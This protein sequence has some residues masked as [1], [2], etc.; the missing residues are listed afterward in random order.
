MIAEAPIFLKLK[1]PVNGFW[2]SSYYGTKVFWRCM[3]GGDRAEESIYCTFQ[4]AL[5]S[6]CS[7]A[8]VVGWWD[9][10]FVLS[11]SLNVHHLGLKRPSVFIDLQTSICYQKK[12]SKSEDRTLDTSNRN[13]LTLVFP[14]MLNFICSDLSFPRNLWNDPEQAY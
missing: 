9:A 1:P 5:V 3:R 10:K 8:L 2:V 4:V 14:Q 7:E 13:Y 6:L 12:L 11:C